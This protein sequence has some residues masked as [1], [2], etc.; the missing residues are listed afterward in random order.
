VLYT[1]PPLLRGARGPANVRLM[2]TFMQHEAAYD[3][4]LRP[5][6]PL[7][8]RNDRATATGLLSVTRGRDLPHGQ[9][10]CCTLNGP[11]INMAEASGNAKRTTTYT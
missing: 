4:L 11:P 1:R 10:R 9:G 6:M 5:I 3:N 2:Q 8:D 7:G